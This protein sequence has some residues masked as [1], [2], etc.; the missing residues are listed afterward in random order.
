MLSLN[1]F[2][3]QLCYDAMPR[4]CDNRREVRIGVVLRRLEVPAMAPSFFQGI[5][6][7]VPHLKSLE[8]S[9][10]EEVCDGYFSTMV[11]FMESFPAPEE[12]SFRNAKVGY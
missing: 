7:L 12:I 3:M 11:A 10:R 8:V 6:G 1:K 5:M 9:I 4:I 2:V